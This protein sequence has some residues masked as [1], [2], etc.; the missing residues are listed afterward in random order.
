MIKNSNKRYIDYDGDNNSTMMRSIKK[1]KHEATPP[2]ALLV[3]E[4]L[5]H[6]FYLISLSYCNDATY[7]DE[8]LFSPFVIGNICK[9]WHATLWDPRNLWI[10][11][12]ML[13]STHKYRKLVCSALTLYELYGP[14]KAT[15]AMDVHLV[16]ISTC[17]GNRTVREIVNMETA[18]QM[19]VY[20]TKEPVKWDLK[21][22]GQY[23]LNF[24]REDQPAAMKLYLIRKSSNVVSYD[25]SAY[26]EFKAVLSMVN[27]MSIYKTFGQMWELFG[28][29]TLFFSNNSEV[30]PKLKLLLSRI[31]LPKQNILRWFVHRDNMCLNL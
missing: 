24:T 9:H 2:T 21:V 14:S 15:I 19:I 11:A 22:K 6:I 3:N 31:I 26:V 18:K 27:M 16:W 29:Q 8:L 10:R 5:V 13:L 17:Y 23:V 30:A 12:N 25:D 1:N 7:S 4:I 28:M 20:G